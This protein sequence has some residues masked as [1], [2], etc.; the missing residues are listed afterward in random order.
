MVY[1]LMKRM[2]DKA[3]KDGSIDEKR[4]DYTEKLNAFYMNNQITTAQYNELMAL[5]NPPAQQESEGE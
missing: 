4:A 5:V 2:I 3:I 1:N